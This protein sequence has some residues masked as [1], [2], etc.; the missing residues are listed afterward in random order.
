MNV[1]HNQIMLAEE[2][3]IRLLTRSAEKIKWWVVVVVLAKENTIILII[4]VVFPAIADD[5]V[6]I[7]RKLRSFL[8]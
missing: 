2:L 5:S 1:M 8:H 3:Q 7:C 6:T 4:I